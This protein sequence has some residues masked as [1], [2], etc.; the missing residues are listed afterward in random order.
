MGR[1]Y[2]FE[3]GKCG[4]RA[5]VAGGADRG[6]HVAVQTVHC[7]ECRELHDA[8][9]ELKVPHLSATNLARWKLKAHRLDAVTAPATPPTFRA[10]LNRVVTGAGKRFSW[11]RYPAACPVSSSHRI[12]EWHQP[13]KCPRCGVFLD[14]NA[15]PF[16]LWD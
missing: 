14:G 7:L 11:V 10:A 5:Q 4:Y 9:T 1:T 12:R 8:V 3:C 2:L 15:I 16:K 6:W 13:G